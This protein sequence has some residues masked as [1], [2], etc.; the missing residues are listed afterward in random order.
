MS[1]ARDV[2]AN[3]RWDN[4]IETTG[5]EQAPQMLLEHGETVWFDNRV[6][7]VIAVPDHLDVLAVIRLGDVLSGDQS[8]EDAGEPFYNIAFFHDTRYDTGNQGLI[9]PDDRAPV[10]FDGQLIV[11]DGTYDPYPVRQNQPK[12]LSRHSGA[13]ALSWQW[14]A[15]EFGPVHNGRHLNF[16]AG[17]PPSVFALTMFIDPM[18][19]NHVTVGVTNTSGMLMSVMGTPRA[20]EEIF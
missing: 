1:A 12:D 5:T 17:S 18:D 6:S 3:E 20:E 4:T 8:H 11:M 16:P 9:V 14:H 2:S 13:V 19:Q 10:G 7:P 15:V